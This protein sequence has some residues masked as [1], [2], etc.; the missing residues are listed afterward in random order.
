MSTINFIKSSYYIEYG[1]SLIFLNI[2]FYFLM[3]FSIFSIFFLF[4]TNKTKVLSDFK[5]F[6]GL[7]LVSLSVFISL[8]SLAGVP[9]LSGFSVKFLTF[10]FLFLSDNF[11]IVFY[12][13][14]LNFFFL[15]FY[16]QNTRSLNSQISNNVSF[17]YKKDNRAIYNNNLLNFIL[18]F[19]IINVTGIF[20]LEDILLYINYVF[21]FLFL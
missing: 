16:I 17:F 8:L 19:N 3:L 21:S 1:Y 4:D 13:A 20:F 11:F 9:P 14:L 5:N 2:I 15:F 7:P 6:N 12:F 18:F 10:M